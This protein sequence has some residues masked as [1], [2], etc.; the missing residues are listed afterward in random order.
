M[1][2]LEALYARRPVV[3]SNVGGMAELI[4]D[5]VNGLTFRVGD[6]GHLAE[7]M[8]FLTQNREALRAYQRN[9]A[10]P[11]TMQD[12]VTDVE[13]CYRELIARHSAEG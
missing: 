6:A 5:G 2:I 12:V 7:K 13:A 11:R 9:I 8:R 4:Q 10:P 3:T 1:A